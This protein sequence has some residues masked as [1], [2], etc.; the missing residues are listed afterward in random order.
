[1]VESEKFRIRATNYD[2]DFEIEVTVHI[3]RLGSGH[4][5]LGPLA[6]LPFHE[7]RCAVHMING[8]LDWCPSPEDT[9]HSEPRGKPKGNGR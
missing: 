2:L 6:I 1:M 3:N 4:G 5:P 8:I 9:S 7:R